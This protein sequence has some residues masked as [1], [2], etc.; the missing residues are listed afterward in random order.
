[1]ENAGT[2]N[3]LN[4]MVNFAAPFQNLAS[5][6]IEGNGTVAGT[7]NNNGIVGPGSSPGQLT[8]AGGF[9][10]SA[11]G[12]LDIELAANTLSFSLLGPPAGATIT[13]GGL[14]NWRPVAALANTTNVLQVRVQDNGAPVLNDTRSFSVIVN[15]LAVPVML[16][17]LGYANGQFTL[18]VTGPFGPDYVIMAS[19]NSAQWSDITTNVSPVLPFQH[20]DTQAGSFSN[21]AY[22]VR[23]QP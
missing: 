22:R 21:R 16:T 9:S 7:L 2:V 20:I 18:G 4:G 10:Q 12:V 11:S 14:F 6:L 8:V 13:S 19:T 15:P 23:L 5:G 3:V 17:P 1:L